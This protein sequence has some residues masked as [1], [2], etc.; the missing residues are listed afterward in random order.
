MLS[1]GSCFR[2]SNA[3]RAELGLHPVRHVLTKWVLASDLLVGLYPEWFAPPI[4]GNGPRLHLTGFPAFD[5]PTAP[6]CS[7]DLEDFL[8]GREPLVFTLGTAMRAGADFFA[9]SAEV[10]R[11]MQRPGLLLTR[12][13]EQIPAHL[14]ESVRHFQHV[15]F[16][17]VL[18][19]SAVLVHHGGIGTV[20]QALRA[21]IPQLISPGNFDQPTNAACACRLGVGS[22]IKREHYTAERVER[23][24]QQLL[25]DKSVR[26]RCRSGREP[27]YRAECG[28]GNV[29]I[30]RIADCGTGGC[31]PAHRWSIGILKNHY[32]PQP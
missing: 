8:A 5:E 17:S 30:S 13:P 2:D 3:F 14:P 26:E 9:V 15:Q 22:S 12:F 6:E 19:R 11:R 27:P 28:V 31:S 18:P 4:P 1:T 10:C 21:G 25:A 24:L 16:S 20:S 32:A 7:Q 29:R 23:K